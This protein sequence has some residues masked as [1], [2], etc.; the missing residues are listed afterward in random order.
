[1]RLS[2]HRIHPL[3]GLALALVLAHSIGCASDGGDTPVQLW[4]GPVGSGS[5]AIDRILF[6]GELRIGMSGDSPPMNVRGRDGE[7]MGLEVDLAR[8]LASAMGVAPML[9]QMP[10][11]QLL[12]AV[13][14]GDVDMAI[15]NLTMTPERNMRVAF[16]GP[17]FV[18]GKAVLTKS[19]TLAAIQ[20]EQA[21]DRSG[22]VLVALDGSTSER[23]LRQV[24]TQ[25]KIVTVPS[26]DD[27]VDM[28]LND[29]ADAMIADYPICAVSLLRYPDAGLEAVAAP[30]TFEPIGIAL[31]PNDP[32]LMN[33]VRNYLVVLE[34]TGLLESLRAK[35][36][37][38]G[39]W[40]SRLP[41][42]I[43]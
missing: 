27:A 2:A 24:T 11:A 4:G 19:S 13:A 42:T 26:Y 33:L 37:S 12:D 31:A 36:F 3:A 21:L 25:A 15:S 10:F 35:W 40:L 1:M 28:V 16:A 18:S 5:I 8:A 7:L 43:R 22:L 34:G 23:M 32:L 39:S 29:S 6:D 9:V 30:F 17:Y 38:E 14:K 20:K 41:V